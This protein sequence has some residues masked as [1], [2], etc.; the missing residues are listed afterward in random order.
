MER[1]QKVYGV[2]VSAHGELRGQEEA[3]GELLLPQ[4]GLQKVYVQLQERW[5][6]P[7]GFMV[8]AIDEDV[9]KGHKVKTSPVVGAEGLLAP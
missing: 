5:Y 1:P 4:A 7:K 6:P 2:G 3:P 8:T 9:D